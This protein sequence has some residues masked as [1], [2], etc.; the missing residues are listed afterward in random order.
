MSDPFT[1]LLERL[2][3]RSERVKQ[4]G[5][6]QLPPKEFECS[7]CEDREIVYFQD[8]D[9][10]DKARFCQC[11]PQKAQKRLFK[12]S[13]LTEE[14]AKLTINDYKPSPE[15]KKM[16]L[17]MREYINEQSWNEGK[18]FMLSGTVGVGKTMLS[19]IV[20]SEIL[21]NG[22]S[23]IFV[24]TN[25]LMAELRA[26][27]FSSDPMDFENKLDMLIKADVAIFDDIGKEKP[28]E[29]VQTQYFRIIDGRYNQRKAT[30]FT[31]NYNFDQLSDRFS[32]FGEALLSRIISMTRDYSVSVDAKDYRLYRK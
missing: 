11:K 16:Y 15:T 12:A 4:S 23:V 28:T 29:W 18:G 8:E 9:G 32:E 3:E 13:G 19:Q 25:S 21:K 14:Q 22:K 26:A 31:S 10:L 27:Q 6:E 17:A 2:K 30:G 5:V 1:Q 24:P 20:A 7:I